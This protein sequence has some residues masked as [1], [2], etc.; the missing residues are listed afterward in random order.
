[1]QLRNA[2]LKI[3]IKESDVEKLD[4]ELFLTKTHLYKKIKASSF[5][6]FDEENEK[7]NVYLNNRFTVIFLMI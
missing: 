5:F 4:F 7:I 2:V 6:T 1:M 3:C